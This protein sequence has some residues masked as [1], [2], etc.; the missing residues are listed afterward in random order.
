MRGKFVI[1]FVFVLLSFAMVSAGSC[2]NNQVIMRL[3]SSANSHVA[4]WNQ[5][6][7][8]Y[9]DEI[10]YNDIFGT[11]YSNSN[12]HDC[13]GN[14]RVLSLYSLSNSHASSVHDAVYSHDVCYGDLSCVYDSSAG[15]S[16]S[17]EGKVV[18]RMYSKTNSHVGEA[19]ENYQ[20][21]VCCRSA[22][23]ETPYWADMSGDRITHADFGD[24]VQMVVPGV[25]FENFSI[26]DYRLILPDYNIR[27]I[28]GKNLNGNRVGVWTIDKADMD[29]AHDYAKFY[30][31]VGS[32]K[33]KYLSIGK[34]GADS[35]MNVTII[36]PI[37][38]KHYDSHSDVHMII[39]ARDADD[40]ITG[41]LKINGVP[42]K[43]FTNGRTFFDKVFSKSGNFQIV[44]ESSNSRGKKSRAISN[45]MILD[46]G[47]TKYIDGDYVAACI[48]SPKDFTNIP[49]TTVNFDASSTRGVRIINGI[50]HE[51]I[52][53]HD[54][55][56]WYWTFYPQSIK[57]NIVNTTDTLAYKFTAEFPIA[58]DNSASLK[59][60][61]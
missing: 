51:L 22:F 37:C 13:N 50:L 35:P 40:L 21:K 61:V 1:G 44:V 45:I 33:S 41:V 3:Y 39:E 20:V 36:S 57:R 4:M 6:V 52:P 56:S 14:N 30:F 54:K 31:E 42:E 38:G 34:N 47:P 24:T 7:G 19:S 32:K 10:C 49:G 15:S 12:P 16:C 26:K 46:K 59:V 23:S 29:K 17:N 2:D 55:F 48:K 43:N 8:A 11:S 9:K 18:A 27:T 28:A 53:G 58:G 25:S 60:E 5:S